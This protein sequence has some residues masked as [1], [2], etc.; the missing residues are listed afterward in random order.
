M[1]TYTPPP[2]PGWLLVLIQLAAVCTITSPTP[3]PIGTRRGHRWLKLT[4]D[5]SR[6][7]CSVTV[8]SGSPHVKPTSGLICN[9]AFPFLSVWGKLAQKSEETGKAS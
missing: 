1:K 2:L 9:I 6:M 8:H 7:A 3:R 5:I 4:R